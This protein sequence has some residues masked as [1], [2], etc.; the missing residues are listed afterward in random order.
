MIPVLNHVRLN[1]RH[2]LTYFCCHQKSPMSRLPPEIV[3]ERSSD[4]DGSVARTCRNCWLIQICWCSRV[5][6]AFSVWLQPI[7]NQLWLCSDG[8]S[9]WPW[10]S[11]SISKHIFTLEFDDDKKSLW[12]TFTISIIPIHLQQKLCHPVVD[13]A[14]GISVNGRTCTLAVYKVRR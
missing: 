13:V 2:H 10:E 7:E 12:C 11:H 8:L 1:F 4:R 14:T 6:F 3:L 5:F 9:S